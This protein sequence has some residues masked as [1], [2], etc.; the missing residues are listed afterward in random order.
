MKITV[1]VS[2][3]VMSVLLCCQVAFGQEPVPE[4]STGQELHVLAIGNSFSESLRQFLVP[5]TESVPGCKIDFKNLYIGGCSLKLHWSN[6]E[7]EAKEPQWRQF[8]NDG[9]YAEILASK[10]WDFV[11]IQQASHFSWQYGTYFP[12]SKNLVDFVREHA[13]SAE[14]VMQQTWSYRNDDARLAQWKLDPESMYEH[15]NEAYT[16]AAAEL[17]IR[18][19]PTGNAVQIARHTCP[20]YKPIAYADL[21]YPDLPD[22]SCYVVGSLQWSNDKTHIQGDTFHLNRRGAYLQACVW[23]EFLFKRSAE[24][25]TFVPEGITAEDAQ[26]LRS[27]AHAAFA[28]AP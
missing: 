12:W 28:P 25:V 26:F 23:F 2:A 3:F 4:K 13:K 17:G 15:L 9:S 1:F 24:E 6:I 22:E 16:K 8:P 10:P 7:R 21:G 20:G 27:A 18:L 14:V 19:I 11:S 5:V